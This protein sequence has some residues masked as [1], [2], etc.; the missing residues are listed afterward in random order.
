MRRRALLSPTPGAVVRALDA[1]DQ[2]RPIDAVVPA[3]RRER[4][5]LR[6]T[7]RSLRGA[8]PPIDP[9]LR[10]QARQCPRYEPVPR[11]A[12]RPERA[13]YPVTSL[14]KAGSCRAMC[15]IQV[16]P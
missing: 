3:G 4:L 14:H 6:L 11:A 12:P 9:S 2:V 5:L 10:S 13:G 16:D 15:R 1:E 7:P 8:S